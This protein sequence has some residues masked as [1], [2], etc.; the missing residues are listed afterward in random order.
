MGTKTEAVMARLK[1][2]MTGALAAAMSLLSPC[3]AAAQYGT[4]DFNDGT[5][6]G[7]WLD[8]AYDE[9]G[10]GPFSSAFTFSWWDMVNYPNVPFNDPNGDGNGSVMLFTSGGHGINNPS[11]TWWIMQFHSPDLSGSG[12]WQGATGYSVELADAMSVWGTLYCNLYVRVYD[13]DQGHDRYFYNG[14]AQPMH[15]YQ[16]QAWN[17]FSF[18]DWSAISGFPT[19]YTVKEV[20]VDIWGLMTD[21]IDGA[22]FLDEVAP[23]SNPPVLSVWPAVLDFGTT[24]INLDFYISNIGG[25]S[26]NWSVAES[27]DKPWITSVWPSSGTDDATVTVTV[28][29]SYLVGDSDT[30]TLSVTSN[31]GNADVTALIERE[32]SITVTSPQTGADWQAGSEQHIQWTSSG[33]SGSVA[34]EISRDGGST[35]STIESSTTDDGDHSWTVT[36]PASGNCMI[37]VSD[38]DGDPSGTSGVFTISEQPYVTV[39]SPQTGDNWQ[40][41]TSQHVLWTSSGTSGSVAIEISRDGGGTWSTIE[42]NTGDDGDHP[43]TVTGPASGN[44][45]VRVSDTDGDPSG[46]SG[47]FTISQEPLVTVTSP[48]AGDDWPIG[49]DQH[50]QWTSSG[51]SGSVT[52]E[53]SRDGGSTWTTLASSTEDDGDCLW[54]VTGPA[55]TSCVIK[56]T[57]ID[58]SPSGES[59]TFS[60]SETPYITVISPSDGAEWQVGTA[61]LIMWTSM[62]TSGTVSI[63]ISRDGGGTWSAIDVGTPDDGDHLWVVSGPL[64]EDCVIRVRDTD[65]SPEGLSGAFTIFSTAAGDPLVPGTLALD[66]LSANPAAGPVTVG[67]AVPEPCHVALGVYDTQGHLLRWL[68]RG[69]L[70]AGRHLFRWDAHRAVPGR[71]VCRAVLR[72]ETISRSLVVCR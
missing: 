18:D 72:G 42:S 54:E 16:T 71:Y 35:W 5:A 17:Y 63:E 8:G 67:C 56:V 70:P 7:W 55:S 3:L 4:F 30:G 58:G 33:T 24:L 57:D 69:P 10:N 50:I 39:T 64:S 9:N 52:I 25:G 6:Q 23:V 62:G 2:I 59:G 51:T 44:C 46:T 66:L 49:S 20:F 38:T 31:G 1:G 68:H 19:N 28:D 11:G 15:H 48:Q 12:T 21:G 60:I 40:I 34:I 47:V 32:S 14:T 53:I 61:Q 29:R 26:L 27:P 45:V 41:G 22:V 37:R 13:H 36:G 43:W 65:G